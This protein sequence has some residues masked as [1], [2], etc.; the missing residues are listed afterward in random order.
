MTL[1]GVAGPCMPQLYPAGVKVH[2]SMHMAL[3]AQVR[4][5]AYSTA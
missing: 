5:A 3:E 4:R 2:G 1:Q